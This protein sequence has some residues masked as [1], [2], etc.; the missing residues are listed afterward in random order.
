MPHIHT[1]KEREAEV[2]AHMNS[3]A[4]GNATWESRR[5]T[6]GDAVIWWD[7]E[8]TDMRIII[9]RKRWSD[10]AGSMVDGR[11]DSQIARMISVRD[12]CPHILIAILVEGRPP[13]EYRGISYESMSKHLDHIMMRYNIHI[14]YSPS[15]QYT[16]NRLYQLADRLEPRQMVQ[17]S[18]APL[19]ATSTAAGA[20]TAIPI[21]S[22]TKPRSR[23]PYDTHLE[24]LQ[25][26]P[27]VGGRNTALAVSAAGWSVRRLYE[28]TDNE[29]AELKYPCGRRIG[30]KQ[31]AKIGTALGTA[32]AWTRIIASVNGVTEETAG[33]I[34][35]ACPDPLKWTEEGLADVVRTKGKKKIGS[36]VASRII[37]TLNFIV[38]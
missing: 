18:T 1:D 25:A 15:A 10:L 36:I 24:M 7:R 6:V 21:V 26:C 38:S 3:E 12:Q 28:A 37:S 19:A 14:M 17:F 4:F 20:P 30:S 22:V 11:L 13:I 31:A 32:A 9:E 16:A 5:L 23:S 27:G 29:I 2:E 33:D 8:L 34:I 35:T